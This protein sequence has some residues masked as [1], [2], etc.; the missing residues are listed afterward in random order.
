MGIDPDA[1][2]TPG[3]REAVIKYVKSDLMDAGDAATGSTGALPPDPRTSAPPNLQPGMMGGPPNLAPGSPQG[4]VPMMSGAAYGGPPGVPAGPPGA[5]QGPA[6]AQAGPPQSYVTPFRQFGVGP[7]PT[8]PG[9][10]P[11]SQRTIDKVMTEAAEL[12]AAAGRA[13]TIGMTGD[14][15]A[16]EKQADDKVK[17]AQKLQEALNKRQEATDPAILA[18]KARQKEL[19]DLGSAKSKNVAGRIEGIK[20]ARDTVQVLDEMDSALT[21]GWKHISTG[22]GARQFLEI[23]KAVNNVMPGTFQNVTEAE[24]VDKLNAQ[25]AAA[26]AKAMTARP[27]QLEFK[28]FMANN[29]GLLTSKEG[30]RVLI[31]LLRQQKQQEI[32]LGGLADKFAPGQ[33]KS[34][35]EIEDKFYR[36]NPII[37]PSTHKPIDAKQANDG[38]WYRPDP[39]RPGKYLEER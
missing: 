29:P 7:Q 32:R 12:R 34:W 9:T 23:K 10:A 3:Q 21:A 6:F 36:D 11:L 18:A 37:S 1:I 24:T 22:P 28:A 39:D 25:L 31:D 8:S 38:K 5:A 19:E 30:S 33:G 15:N 2:L 14:A 35:S 4:P 27:S 17:Y 26:A 13:A 16:K 20:P